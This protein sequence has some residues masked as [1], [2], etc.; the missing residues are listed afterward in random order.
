[1]ASGRALLIAA[2]DPGAS[3]LAKAV[4]ADMET[5]EGRAVAR[6]E[7]KAELGGQ[8]ACRTQEPVI[9]KLTKVGKILDAKA[10]ADA[11]AFKGWL[12]HIAD[13]VA[14]AASEGRLSG[15]L[16]S[17]MRKRL[18]SQRLA[19]RSAS[20][21]APPGKSP[22]RRSAK[23]SECDQRMAK[24]RDKHRVTFYYLLAEKYG[25]LAAFSK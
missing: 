8:D 21:D 1:M 24:D 4:V 10:P 11:P 2:T 25:K 17:R 7:L 15:A 5:S 3:D 6:E 13:K 20:P 16:R 19:K 9:A 18:R 23:S 12:K 14:E 22:P